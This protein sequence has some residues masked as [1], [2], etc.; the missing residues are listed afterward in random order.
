MAPSV[1]C[2]MQGPE[3][4]IFVS[5]VRIKAG[6]SSVLLIV[7]GRDRKISRAYWPVCIAYLVST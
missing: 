2:L 5:N 7:G 4:L 3:D 1:K 6:Y